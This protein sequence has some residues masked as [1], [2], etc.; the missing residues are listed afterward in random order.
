MVTTTVQMPSTSGIA[1]A[2]SD[3]NTASNTIRTIGRFHCSAWAMSCLVACG[4]GRAERALADDVELDLAVLDLTG[5]L[6]VDADLL[7]QLL[8]DVDRAG[9]V[10]VQLQRD[11]VRSVGLRGR[12]LRIGHHLARW[13]PR[14]RCAPDARR[15]RSCPRTTRRRAAR[16]PAPAVT[17]PDPGSGPRARAG[18]AATGNLRPRN[19]R[20]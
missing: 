9:V 17:H 7:A 2:A 20:R 5:L 14:R 19:R 3:P 13:A 11:D 1:A 15:R 10:E 4:R 8:G 16:R 6:A 12:L 18:R